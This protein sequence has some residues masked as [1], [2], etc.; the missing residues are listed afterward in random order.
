MHYPNQNLSAIRTE[1]KE[2]IWNIAATLIG[3][4]D[5]AEGS[6]Q[7]FLLLIDNSQIAIEFICILEDEY[8]VE[9]DDDQICLDFFSDIDY[10]VE[11]IL[12][13][14]NTI[15]WNEN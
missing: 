6:N 8:E 10:I 3:P 11:C 14:T 2:R 5:I 12:K 13:N 9:F 4:T 7:I 15:N 1:I